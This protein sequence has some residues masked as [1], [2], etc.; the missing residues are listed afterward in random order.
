MTTT[1]SA[2][3][4][5]AVVLAAGCYSGPDAPIVSR[6]RTL[7]AALK[8]AR[9]SDRLTIYALEQGSCAGADCALKGMDWITGPPLLPQVNGHALV[10]APRVGRDREVP[11]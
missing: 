5:H 4:T 8:A 1:M 11:A 9:R 10:G 2:Q 3:Y 7:A 6:H